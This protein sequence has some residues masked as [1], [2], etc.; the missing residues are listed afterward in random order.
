[1]SLL[2]IL[3]SMHLASIPRANLVYAELVS[4]FDLSEDLETPNPFRL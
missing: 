4:R 1:M 2:G 3:F